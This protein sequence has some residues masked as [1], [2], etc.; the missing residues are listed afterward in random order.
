[1][2]R[3]VKLELENFK[4]YKG[5]Q[6]IGPFHNFSC[7]IGPNGAGKSNLMDAISFVLGIKSSQLRS[8]HLK[9]LIYRGGAITDNDSPSGQNN[10]ENGAKKAWVMAEYQTSEGKTLRFTRTVTLNG[11]SEYRFNN[12]LTTYEKYNKELEKENILVKAKNFLVFQGDVEAIASQSPKD[13]TR[14]IEQVSGSLELKEEYERLK[15][16]QEKATEDS[17]Y[18][19][20]KKRGIN[21]EMKQFKKQK[22]EAE[23]YKQLTKKLENVKLKYMLWKLFQMDENINETNKKIENQDKLLRTHTNLKVIILNQE[24]K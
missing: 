2:G 19:F 16:L 10:D 24:T 15:E 17:T 4:S 18:N 1:M 21:A 6:V 5:H 14:L 22:E 7:I 23:M 9:D 13:L 11:S 12:K 20:N 3:L 8:S